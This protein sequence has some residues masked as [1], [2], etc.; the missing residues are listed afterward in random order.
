MLVRYILTSVS[1]IKSAM[2]FIELCVVNLTISL[3]AIASTRLLYLIGIIK[4]ELYH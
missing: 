1:N 3:G 2:Q 4:S